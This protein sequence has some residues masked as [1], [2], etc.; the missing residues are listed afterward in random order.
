M[1]GSAT[2][3]PHDKTYTAELSARPGVDLGKLQA[4]SA[5]NLKIAGVAGLNA[6]GQGSFDD[7]QIDAAV[8]IPELAVQG[9]KVTGIKL[10]WQTS[11]IILRTR[12][13][14]RQR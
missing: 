7:P 8:E 3:R 6:K 2:V 4:V 5:R 12:R 1:K 11:R 14:S 13:C 10:Q 9:Q